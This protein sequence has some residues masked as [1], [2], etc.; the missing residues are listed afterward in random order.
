MGIRIKMQFR[1]HSLNLTIMSFKI[2]QFE[3]KFDAG[4]F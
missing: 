4:M 1:P 3:K 2:S